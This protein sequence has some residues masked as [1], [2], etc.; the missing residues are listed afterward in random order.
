MPTITFAFKNP[1]P[2]GVDVP[3]GDRVRCAL[4]EPETVGGAYRSTREFTVP[5]IAGVGAA[6]L[7]QG[8]WYCQV[9]G[10]EGVSERWVTV[11][12][13][14]GSIAFAALA[15]VDPRLYLPAEVRPSLLALIEQAVAGVGGGASLVVTPDPDHP[16][17]V[18]L[19][20]PAA[21]AV[22]L[23]PVPV[24]VAPGGVATF[25]AAASGVPAPA[26]RW[27]TGSG[28]TWADI[29]GATST[30]YTVPSPQVADTGKQYRAVFTST[31]GQAVTVTATL[32]VSTGSV[33]PTITLQ[34]QDYNGVAGDSVTLTADA[35]G[36]PTPT[37]Q[38]QRQTIVGDPNSWVNIAGATGK[39]LTFTAAGGDWRRAIF[40]NAS[41][42]ATTR[43]AHVYG[44]IDG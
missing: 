35:S 27:Q 33:P 20:A 4:L 15:D 40:T 8:I 2:G 16:W 44:Y 31:A 41:G 17:A 19:S 28:D 3:A 30:S 10:V 23:Q 18:I 38:W 37:I 7:E 39:T 12:A 34:P 32:T 36:T 14:S 6:V 13:G 9:D 21:P 25:T 43:I 42:T 24:V 29:P 5:L 11:P 22:T 1:Q 26:V